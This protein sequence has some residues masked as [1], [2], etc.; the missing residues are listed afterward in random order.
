MVGGDAVTG[1]AAYATCELFTPGA[2]TWAV[3]GSMARARSWGHGAIQLNNGKVLVMGGTSDGGTTYHTIC[4]LYD[5]TTGTWTDTGALSYS[6]I[7]FA[8]WLLSNGKVLVTGGHHGVGTDTNI[9]ELY[10]PVAGTWSTTGALQGNAVI[11]SG[12]P[13]AYKPR[14]P[15]FTTLGDGRPIVIGGTVNNGGQACKNV[16]TYDIAAGTW[17]VQANATDYISGIMV[18]SCL[19]LTNGNALIVAPDF[20]QAPNE[21][22][23]CYIYNQT[24]NTM[25]QTGSTPQIA[26]GSQVFLITD[27][28]VVQAGGS[29]DESLGALAYSSIYDPIAGTWT[30]LANIN[31]ARM[32]TMRCQGIVLDDGRCFFPGGQ[33]AGSNATLATSEVLSAVFSTAVASGRRVNVGSIPTQIVPSF[34]G[35][36]GIIVYNNGTKVIYVGFDKY[37][38]GGIPVLPQSNAELANVFTNLTYGIWGMSSYGVQDVRYAMWDK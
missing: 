2:D 26:Q 20:D 3:T 30:A 22:A 21:R 11:P 10:D 9:C 31:T 27:G 6:R 37:L 23:S 33:N 25:A 18:N 15:L 12:G 29:S 14:W 16:Q 38:N 1:G 32:W 8:F 5:P 19:T 24:T 28:Y 36:K 17:T 7:Q 35:R 4:E 13:F 34:L